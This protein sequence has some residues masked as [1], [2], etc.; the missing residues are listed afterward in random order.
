MYAMKED[1]HI[2]DWDKFPKVRDALFKWG[3][4]NEGASRKD[5]YEKLGVE[6]QKVSSPRK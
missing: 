3:L 6:V 2:L 4:I 5:I 1:K